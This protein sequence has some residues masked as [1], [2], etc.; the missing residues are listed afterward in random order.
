MAVLPRVG[1]TEVGWGAGAPL[2][3]LFAGG[4]IGVLQT[5]AAQVVGLLRW[6]AGRAGWWAVELGTLTWL[7]ATSVLLG[8]LVTRRLGAYRA[9][10]AAMIVTGRRSTGLPDRPDLAVPAAAALGS[11]LAVPLATSSVAWAAVYGGGVSTW[12]AALHALLG[13]VIGVAVAALAQR[14]RPVASGTALG[15][16]VGW[17]LAL[18]SVLLDPG[19]PPVLG[20][21]DLG[22]PGDGGNAWAL[23]AGALVAAL[24]LGVGVGLARRSEPADV[25][26]AVA[27]AG[28]ALMA[29]SY[30]FVWPLSGSIGGPSWPW[31]PV[32]S[33]LL[34]VPVAAGV[35]VLT[36]R[37]AGPGWLP[38]RSAPSRG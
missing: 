25:R 13:A 31:S 24:L 11:L 27:A 19:R 18:L 9:R 3:A 38:W 23:R 33:A 30:L 29:I 32:P 6:D 12:R 17:V 15:T 36:G 2:V 34:A 22:V 20:H 35:A 5:Q 14:F 7:V 4:L 1:P 10:R 28:P 8:V 21:P 26:I 16:L 37:L